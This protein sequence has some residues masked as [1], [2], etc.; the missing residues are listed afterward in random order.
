[1]DFRTSLLNG[2]MSELSNYTNGWQQEKHILYAW[3]TLSFDA[4]ENCSLSLP[5]DLNVSRK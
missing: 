5:K 3:Y 4:E 2:I 1:M